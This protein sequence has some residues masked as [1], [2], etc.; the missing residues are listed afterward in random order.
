MQMMPK[1]IFWPIIDC[2]S[3]Y[4]TKELHAFNVLFYT[5]SERR[6]HL[7]YLELAL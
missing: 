7:E 4:A 3:L 2:S 5:E 6:G 1:H